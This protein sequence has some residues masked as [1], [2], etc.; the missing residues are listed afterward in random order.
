[1]PQGLDRRRVADL[2]RPSDNAPDARPQG[3]SACGPRPG[4]RRWT[5]SPKPS[6]RP[7]RR[8]GLG[9]GRR[10]RRR[11]AD[12]RE[13][14][15]AG[16]VRPRGAAARANI[17]Y[18]GRFCMASAAAAGIKA[19]GIDRGLPFPLED[20]A[21]TDVILLV[22]G[23]P[24][25]TMPPMMQYFEEQQRRRRPA[26][27]R[28]SAAH[29]RPRGRGDAAS[30]AHAG[31]RW[32][33]RQRPAA[34]RHVAARSVGSR[35]TSHARTT[36]FDAVRRAVAAYWP[37]RVER[38]T[39]V[40]AE[41][42]EQA[43]RML[44]EPP[45]GHDPDRARAGAAEQGRRQRAGLHQSGAGA[46]QGRQAVLRL[47]LPSPGR[48]TA[49]AAASTARRPTS[50]PATAASTTR[51]TARTSRASGASTPRALPGPGLSAYELLDALGDRRRRARAAG[52]WA[53]TS[54]SRRPTSTHVS[55]RLAGARPA[56]GL[57]HLP[58]RDRRDGRRRAADRRSGPR[59]KAP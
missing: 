15:P 27:R 7:S 29:R 2:P 26:D 52:A 51:R 48:A 30:A 37:D 13:G 32:R 55:E 54:R 8:H 40:P 18:N 47:R 28:R 57:R 59:R 6:A 22:G 49:R 5:A 19:F 12:Q 56:G 38:I 46:R 42:I 34:H 24:A 16:Q 9:C 50:C 58:V 21:E 35:S 17:D 45:T 23:N 3:R 36:G 31:H 25:E 39:G 1:M 14:L 33:A 10:V 11:R 20:I 41:A 53:P 43:A 4:T 44:G